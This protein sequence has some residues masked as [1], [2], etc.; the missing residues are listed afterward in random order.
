MSTRPRWPDKDTGDRLD[1]VADFSK[2][3]DSDESIVSASWTITPSGSANDIVNAG[4]SFSGQ[5]A[6]IF[7]SKGILGKA[8]KVEVTASTNKGSPARIYNR[9]IDIQVQDL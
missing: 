8:Y 9:A 7:L 1:Y 5:K 2:I 6:T 4:D 3:F